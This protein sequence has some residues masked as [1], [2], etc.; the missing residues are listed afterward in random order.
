MMQ[1]RWVDQGGVMQVG[2]LS[3]HAGKAS[4]ILVVGCGNSELSEDMARDS[5]DPAKIVSVDFSS[6]SIQQSAARALGSDDARV[7]ALQYR[8]ADCRALHD[9]FAASSFECAVDKGASAQERL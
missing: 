8:V 1:Y 7:R 4:D 9:V 5:W 2:A 6:T 3:D